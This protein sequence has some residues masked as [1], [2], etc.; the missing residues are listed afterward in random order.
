[1][2]ENPL[3]TSLDMNPGKDPVVLPNTKQPAEAD[4]ACQWF[5]CPV[6]G[7]RQRGCVVQ[8]WWD[9]RA[10]TTMTAEHTLQTN[11]SATQQRAACELWCV[12]TCLQLLLERMNPYTL[13][14]VR[15]FPSEDGPREP[16]TPAS[17]T[18][19]GWDRGSRSKG[20]C[21]RQHGE[22]QCCLPKNCSPR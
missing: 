15:A 19:A 22:Q 1:M 7:C 16:G 21:V 10:R 9:V 4:F 11:T 14:A 20:I 3:Q 2:G 18:V 5:Y 6:T 8:G 12:G 17:P 13:C